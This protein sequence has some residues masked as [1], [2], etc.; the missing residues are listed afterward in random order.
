MLDCIY[1]GFININSDLNPI[2]KFILSKGHGGIA[3][4]VV[5]EQLRFAFGL[6]DSYCSSGG[7]VRMP[8][9]LWLAWY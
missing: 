2:D 9:R 4:Y 1:N 7:E 5:L 8:S 6:V 3:Q